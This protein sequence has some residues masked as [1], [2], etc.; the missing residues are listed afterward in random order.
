[1]R[2]LTIKNIGDLVAMQKKGNIGFEGKRAWRVLGTDRGQ[3][4]RI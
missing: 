4:V 3:L 1:M 2:E